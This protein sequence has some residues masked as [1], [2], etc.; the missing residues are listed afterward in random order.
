M[1][2]N[3]GKSIFTSAN[4]TGTSS[5]LPSNKITT[6]VSTDHA[7]A[8]KIGYAFVISDKLLGRGGFGNV[9][10]AN[11]ENGNRVAIKCCDIKS[12]GIPNILEA[13]IMGTIIHPY[14]NRALRIQASEHKLY[15]IQEVAKSDLSQHTRRDR[16]NFKPP[17]DLLRKWCYSLA[18]AV[19]VLHSNGI[20]HADIKSGNV[21]I[22]DDDSVKLTDFT[23]ATKKWHKDQQFEHN[24]CTYTHRP[25]ECLLSRKWDESLDIWAL[26]CTFYEIAYGE[27][28][29]PYQ[30]VLEPE[31]VEKDKEYKRRLRERSINAIIDWSSRGPNPP[32]SFEFIGIKSYPIDY[33]PFILRDDYYE[34]EMSDFNDLW[35]KML[36]VDPALRPTIKEVMDHKF[37]TGLTPVIYM[38]VV[39]PVN[40]I[41]VAEH[42][43]VS[44]YIQRY[45]SN[46]IIQELALILYRRCNNITTIN[47]HVQAATCTWI[48]S[49]IVVGYPPEIQ[50]NQQQLL[51]AERDI[52]H[53]LLFRLH[54]A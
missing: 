5:T 21:L 8:G 18:Q 49:K 46:P 9:Y 13:S 3:D 29:F 24:A 32:T 48:A 25:L 23:L 54:C 37:F 50:I 28:L 41:P 27:L 1:T 12:T 34:P 26:G 35:C 31:K 42:A 30:G 47:E 40:I 36:S 15:I 10:L 38:S 20:I 52:C 17:I 43:R 11:D 45:S 2:N 22:Y 16:G 6:V 4:V 51:S 19:S 44:R 39:R 53:N 33:L 14:L 7:L